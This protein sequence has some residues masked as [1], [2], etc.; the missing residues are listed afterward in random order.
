MDS[1]SPALTDILS[2]DYLAWVSDDGS[3]ER[4]LDIHDITIVSQSD[5]V[6]EA[7]VQGTAD[8]PYRVTLTAYGDIVL[9]TCTCPVEWNWCKHAIA[10]GLALSPEDGNAGEGPWGLDCAAVEER[11]FDQAPRETLVQVLR[12]YPVENHADPHPLLTPAVLTV[13]TPQEVAALMRMAMKS[14][15]ETARHRVVTIKKSKSTYGYTD[16]L[17]DIRDDFEG[18]IETLN[19]LEEAGRGKYLLPVIEKLIESLLLLCEPDL[20][21]CDFISLLL[22]ALALH[23]RH[24]QGVDAGSTH[25]VTWLARTIPSILEHLPFHDFTPYAVL[26]ERKDLVAAADAAEARGDSLVHAHLCLLLGKDALLIAHLAAEEEWLLLVRYYTDR[27]RLDEARAVIRN[28]WDPDSPAWID[29]DDLGIL[30]RTYLPMEDYL[31]WLKE[32]AKT[33]YWGYAI[34]YVQHPLVSYDDAMAL[35]EVMK[36]HKP[37]IPYAYDTRATLRFLT[38]AH[39]K[40]IDEALQLFYTWGPLIQPDYIADFAI[41]Q[42]P[43][44]HP[45]TCV[46]MVRDCAD[47][48]VWQEKYAAAAT[49]LVTLQR[50]I[51]ASPEASRAARDAVIAIIKEHPGDQDLRCEFNCKNLITSLDT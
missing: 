48:L 41:D 18:T 8:E 10:V 9:P 3:F 31:H 17:M 25:L 34:E 46:E 39:H 44:T 15:A 20:R 49:Y 47:R 35:I 33:S 11:F 45:L 1:T 4:A 37:G 27:D 21:I 36:H 26:T 32:R 14:L 29:D 22:K 16:D 13:G 51:A 42:L 2:Y 5:R 19:S 28:A 40:R 12:D 43:K 38:A 6:V 50:V 23:L 24:C 7:D 30:I